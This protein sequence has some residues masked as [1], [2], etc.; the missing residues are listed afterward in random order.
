MWSPEGRGCLPR[1]SGCHEWNLVS[2]TNCCPPTR[3][4]SEVHGSCGH[5]KTERWTWQ[6]AFCGSCHWNIHYTNKHACIHT[7]ICMY[8]YVNSCKPSNTH[9]CRC[10]NMCT[11]YLCNDKCVD[12]YASTFCMTW[13]HTYTHIHTHTQTYTNIHTYI[14]TYTHPHTHTHIQ[15]YT[16]LSIHPSRQTGRSTDIQTDRRPDGHVDRNTGRNTDR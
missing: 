14:H 4:A 12:V 3:A 2:F 6:M 7:Y 11:V 13:L 9:I 5:V 10:V 8:A 15:A 16:H 1:N